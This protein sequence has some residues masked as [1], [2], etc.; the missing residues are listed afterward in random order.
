MTNIW[1]YS[2]SERA[3]FSFEIDGKR[4]PVSLESYGKMIKSGDIT[5]DKWWHIAQNWRSIRIDDEVLIYSGDQDKGV[6]GYATVQGIDWR[7]DYWAIHM[8]FNLDRSRTLLKKPIP[9]QTV[10]QWVHYPRKNV[11]NV[12]KYKSNIY[13]LLP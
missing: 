6:I 2:I 10:R 7:G 4:I 11:I 8:K 9:A 1:V 3:E 12:T 13:D 5:K